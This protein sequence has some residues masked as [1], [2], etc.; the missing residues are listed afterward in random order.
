LGVPPQVWPGWQV[1][2]PQQ[3][4]PVRPQHAGCPAPPQQTAFWQ[5]PTAQVCVFGTHV[6][7][8]SQQPFAPVTPLQRLPLQH[9]WLPPPQAWH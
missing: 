7:V 5:V 4:W 6:P 1:E 8:V 2:P 3:G 9:A